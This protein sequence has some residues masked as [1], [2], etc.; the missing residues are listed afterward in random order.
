MSKN[1]FTTVISILF[2][3][4]IFIQNYT[5]N[6]GFINIGLIIIPICLSIFLFLYS[7]R[8]IKYYDNT[9]LPIFIF[10]VYLF[11]RGTFSDDILEAV[12]YF[13]YVVLCILIMYLT[14]VF[15]N[16]VI[17]FSLIRPILITVNLLLIFSIGI[18]FYLSWILTP[19]EISILFTA[20]REAGAR[21]NREI[22]SFVTSESGTIR[23]NGYYFD[24]NYWAMY[25]TMALTIISC[26]SIILFKA[27]PKKSLFIFLFIIP[28]ILAIVL[29]F[30]RGA[31]LSMLLSSILLFFFLYKTR[32]V[33]FKSYFL[34]SA[35]IVFVSS[36]I[37]LS[38][39]TEIIETFVLKFSNENEALENTRSNIWGLYINHLSNVELDKLIFGYGLKRD[40]SIEHIKMSTHNLFLYLIVKQGLLGL[41]S[42][43]LIIFV[44]IKR[45][46]FIM[47][48]NILH[49]LSSL[50]VLAIIFQSFF[51]DPL[52]HLP[53][54]VL[55][56]F[57]SS[58]KYYIKNEEFGGTKLLG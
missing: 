12:I 31:I 27:N 3:N 33:F 49:I 16:Y 25:A 48:N 23:F 51:L 47:K 8:V 11:I 26:F 36:F 2:F 29:T 20:F 41:F 15:T 56:A 28:S 6:L 17:Q 55:I 1:I 53:F 58:I 7:G 18:Y 22:T 9:N 13:S 35:A 39:L 46:F 52:Y 45:N 32:S 42:Y 14:Y 34:F 38:F 5:F 54:W 37:F 10:L 19:D 43:L 44:F 24:P 30:S 21:S 40:P 4:F 57:N 50:G